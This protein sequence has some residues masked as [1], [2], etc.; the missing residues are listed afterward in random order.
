MLSSDLEMR[1]AQNCHGYRPRY[2]LGFI[3]SIS[4][5]SQSCNSCVYYVKE[6]CTQGLFDEIREIIR[7]N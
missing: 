4:Y 1:I 2:N 3:N 7:A 5:G 6:K